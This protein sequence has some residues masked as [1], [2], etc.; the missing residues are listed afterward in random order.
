MH[1]LLE[2][3]AL[4]KLPLRERRLAISMTPPYPKPPSSNQLTRFSEQTRKMS[5]GQYLNYLPVIHHLLDPQRIPSIA[6]LEARNAEAVH[7]ILAAALSL[8]PLFVTAVPP[9]AFPEIWTRLCPWVE[10]ISTHH[11]FLLTVTHCLTGDKLYPAFTCFLHRMWLHPVNQPIIISTRECPSIAIHAWGFILDMEDFSHK[12]YALFIIHEL[13]LRSSV[14][15]D[16]VL[17]AVGGRVDR[18]AQLIMQQ[19]S[20]LVHLAPKPLRVRSPI[21]EIQNSWLVEYAINIVVTLDRIHS[22]NPGDSTRLCSAL[23]PLGFIEIVTTCACSLVMESSNLSDRGMEITN[24][25]IGVLCSIFEGSSTHWQHTLRLSIKHG[26]L[27]LI[28]SC[29]RWPPNQPIHN[30]LNNLMNDYLFQSTVQY[31]TLKTLEPF[32]DLLQ[33]AEEDSALFSVPNF[34]DLWTAF[35]ELCCERF[36]IRDQFNGSPSIRACDN[37]E[38]GKICSKFL[39]KCCSGCNT[40]LYCSRECQ[41]ADWQLGH[42]QSCIWHLSNRN[43]IC[44]QFSPKEYS[45]LR[46]LLQH[47]YLSRRLEFVEELTRCWVTSPQGLFISVYDYHNRSSEVILKCFDYDLADQTGHPEYLLDI[48]ARVERSAG[49]MS[50]DIMRVHRGRRCADF[51]IPLRR[52]TGDM[53]VSLR[54]VARSFVAGRIPPPNFREILCRALQEEGRTTR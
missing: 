49:R 36:H 48:K 17:D 33:R 50:L 31:H 2:L 47:D 34:R 45:F 8:A 20:P 18:I 25:C 15:L 5:G 53:E 54:N 1:P 27:N 19:I 10:F 7:H 14:A 46:F 26:L 41:V 3:K 32:R 13:M 28:P 52:E 4:K 44:V 38:C 6:A 51:L 42:R 23:V 35:S 9:D 37:V 16:D 43:R 21:D 12:K 39:L 22:G 11:D 30:T 24:S 40:L 29:A